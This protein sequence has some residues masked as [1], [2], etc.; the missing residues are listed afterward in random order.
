MRIGLITPRPDHPLLAATVALLEP[1]HDIEW[2]DPSG[3]RPP[4]PDDPADVYLLKARTSRAVA[5]A[6]ELEE[7][8]A[9]VLNSAAATSRCQDRTRMAELARAA[10]LPFAENRTAARL[11]DLT[12][13]DGP[14]PLVIKSRHS[15]RGDLVTRVDTFAQLTEL[16]GTWGDEP[17]VV[18]PFTEG[19]GWDRKLWVLGGEVFAARRHSE[20]QPPA[21]TPAPEPAPTPA[22][23]TVPLR[24]ADIPSTWRELA[25]RTGRVFALDIYGVDILLG[26]SGPVIVDINAFPGARGQDGAPE[27]LASL[28]VRTAKAR[29]RRGRRP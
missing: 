21:P 29:G 20:L 26:P 12:E 22:P 9:L 5:L 24:P 17:V 4:A 15:R 1:E 10:G 27:A 28:A 19:D 8:G 6:A 23:R 7:R 25:L 13:R 2:L 14:F 16:Y 3:P 11:R 18:Q